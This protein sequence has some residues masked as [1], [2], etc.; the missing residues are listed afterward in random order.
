[1][2]TTS[3]TNNVDISGN[4]GEDAIPV[5]FSSNTVTT[6]IVQGLTVQKSADKS[7][8]VNGPLTYSI[9]ITNNSGGKLAGGELQDT[10]NTAL[11][12]FSQTYGV[13]IDD[14]TTQDFTYESGVLKV[15]LPE[16]ADTESKTIKF[17]VTLN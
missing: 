3:L 17:Q 10:I 16:I 7:Y 11:V 4:Y 15:T 9:V 13:T 8:W 5:T 12:T 14:T 2:A 6:T 1:M